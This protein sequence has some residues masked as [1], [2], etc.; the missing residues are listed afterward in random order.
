MTRSRPPEHAL[1]AP[2]LARYLFGDPI[3]PD[4]VGLIGR[5]GTQL[6]ATNQRVDRLLRLAWAIFLTLVVALLTL[7]TDLILRVASVGRL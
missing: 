3:N 6:E 2:E 5:L 4:D 1:T 7:A